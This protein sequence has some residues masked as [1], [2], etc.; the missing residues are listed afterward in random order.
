M[1]LAQAKEPLGSLACR[2]MDLSNELDSVLRESADDP[3]QWQP[4]DALANFLDFCDD[5][6]CGLDAASL[7]EL[8]SKEK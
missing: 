3:A 8:L 5:L 1:T 4:G 2:L 7:I 6:P